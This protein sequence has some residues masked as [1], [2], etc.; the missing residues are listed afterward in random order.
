[1]M[2]LPKINRRGWL[3]TWLQDRR[4][5]RQHR[6]LP[7]PVLAAAYP[8]LAVWS[9]DYPNPAYWYAYHQHADGEPF[10]Y[11]DRG[12]GTDRQYAPD[13]GQYLM[14][15]VGV[16][17]DGNEVTERSNAVRPDDAVP[18]P[19]APVITN[20]GYEWGATSGGEAA[21]VWI[22]WTFDY[23]VYP[24]ADM[25]V[26]MSMD[27]NNYSLLATVSSNNNHYVIAAATDGEADYWFKIRY[28][29]GAAVGPF[30]DVFYV[31]VSL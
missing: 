25:E 23:G 7:A 6:L 29:N 28:R 9:W 27:Q 16:D 22:D 12:A 20:G 14:F 24:V 26:W 15:I 19:D 17:A 8:D 11:D 5:A 21:D 18:P 31:G 2:T 4:R 13:G 10:T 3:A 1:M 30:S